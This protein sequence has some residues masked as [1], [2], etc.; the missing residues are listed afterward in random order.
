MSRKFDGEYG[1]S[2]RL[3]TEKIKREN[4]KRKIRKKRNIRDKYGKGT[5][6]AKDWKNISIGLEMLWKMF[7]EG[8]S[9][10]RQQLLEGTKD[11]SRAKK[12][13]IGY[14]NVIRDFIK[15]LKNNAFLQYD[16]KKRIEL[17]PDYSQ[18]AQAARDGI[19]VKQATRQEIINGEKTKVTYDTP[20]TPQEVLDILIEYDSKIDRLQFEKLENYLGLGLGLAGT[21]GTLLNT[22]KQEGNTVK[23]GTVIT[24]LTT[25]ISGLKL[26]QG[27]M[28]KDEKR[29]RFELLDEEHRLTSDLLENEQISEQAIE[30]MLESIRVITQ[31]R[32]KEEIKKDNRNFLLEGA[33]DL[34]AALIS[35][36]YIN[37]Q[38][39]I[40]E[41]GKIDGKSL[42]KAIMSIQATTGIARNFTNSIEGIRSTRKTEAEF[43]ELCKKVNEII[44]QMEEKVYPLQPVEHS[45]D[46]IKI[47]DFKG[48]FYPKRNYE[49]QEVEYGATLSILEFS[50]RRGDIVLLSGESGSGKST[51]LRLLKRGDINNRLCI[52]INDREKVDCLGREYISF[53]PSINLG[54]EN[55][56]LT[57]I[58]GK[59]NISELTEQEKQNLIKIMGELNLD[60][61]NLLEQLATKKFMEF[62]TGQQKRLALSKLFYRIDDGTSVIIVDEPVGNVEDSLIRQQLEMIKEYAQRKNVMLIL[63]THRLDLAEDLATKRYHI[64]QDGVMVQQ[65]IKEKE[66]YTL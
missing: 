56:V 21:L 31:K 60:F 50:M 11:V 38:I 66:D 37:G 52:Q 24:L 22:K 43:E 17:L 18:I 63:T 14:I 39:Q 32:R 15:K 61:P 7:N 42:A 5:L 26:I 3:I 12:E 19:I 58:T 41:N 2:I 62:S 55:S 8:Y 1:I 25:A 13:F 28:S 34:V 16:T 20:M 23:S 47:E 30:E 27:I 59:Q 9:V 64:S 49:T 65:P 10:Q 29:R 33:M 6:S 51:F 54:N 57:Q 40:N 48:K 35:G 46:S 44:S 53:R 36:V 4:P 45:F